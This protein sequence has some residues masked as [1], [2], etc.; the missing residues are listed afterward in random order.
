VGEVG[1]LR[2]GEVA[3]DPALRGATVDGEERQVDRERAQA[4][5]LPVVPH[6][7]AGVVE[8]VG[9][10][11]DHVAEVVAPS[12]GI[13]LDRLVGGGDGGDAETLDL[14]LSAVVEAQSQNVESP[15]GRPRRPGSPRG[16]RERGAH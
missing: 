2:T 16:S 15:A 4:L 8:R 3:R 1:G 11:A 14:D 6:A 10:E 13:A 7:V 9:T 5:D 12:R